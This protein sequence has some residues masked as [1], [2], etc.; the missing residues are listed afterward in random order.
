ML[1]TYK[2]KL[3]VLMNDL[4]DWEDTGYG[5]FSFLE[6]NE[7]K[8]EYLFNNASF[9]TVLK[10][11]M[12]N[13]LPCFSVDYSIFKNTPFLWYRNI[14]FERKKIVRKT[15]LKISVKKTYVKVNL[16]LQEIF[17]K[18]PAEQTIEYLKQRDL[19]ISLEK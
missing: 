11:V 14:G 18:L 13:D 1:S 10:Y 12:N 2:S 19:I 6:D 9:D 8:E 17:D 7:P 15:D 5:G 3:Y 16:S 4:E